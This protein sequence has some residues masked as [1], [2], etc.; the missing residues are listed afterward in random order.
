MGAGALG[1]TLTAG[2]G[3]AHGQSASVIVINE[4]GTVSTN[5]TSGAAKWISDSLSPGAVSSLDIGRIG[6][7]TAWGGN[8]Y[9]YAY[10]YALRGQPAG[11][12]IDADTGVM[13]ISSRLAAGT[14]SFTVVVTNRGNTGLSASFPYTL[15]VATGITSGTPGA[16]QVLH[17]TYDPHSGA[18]GRPT[19]NNWTAVFNAMQAAI[20][21]DQ[22]AAGDGRLRVSIPLHRGVQYDYTNNC[23]LT[24]IQYL[25]VYATGSGA[26]PN[27]RCTVVGGVAT[28]AQW[29]PLFLGGDVKTGSN[30][31]GAFS[32][33]G[34]TMKAHCAPIAAAAAGHTTVT[35]KTSGDA[36][37]IKVG[38]W[39]VVCSG[40]QQ[41][42][43]YPPN[44]TWIDYVRVTAVSGTTVRL[45]RPLK[46]AHSSTFWE[47]LKDD[48]S[49]GVARLVP[50]DTGG[51]GGYVPSM[52]RVGLRVGMTNI[53]FQAN[54][55][56]TTATS[57]ISIGQIDVSYAGCTFVN[58][59]PTI[60]KHTLWTGCT[61]TTS[62]EP[63]K[64]CET[65]VID[66]C[67]ASAFNGTICIGGSTGFLYLLIR[68]SHLPPLQICPRQLR[69]MGGSKIDALGDAHIC[70]PLGW[71]YNGPLMYWSVENSTLQ[72]SSRQPTCFWQQNPSGGWGHGLGFTL[73]T[74]CH[75]G[76]GSAASQLRFPV[77]LAGGSKFENAL[78]WCYAGM[79]VDAGTGFTPTTA[80]YGY[81]SS[82][83]SP[84]DGS[85]LWLNVVWVNGTKPTSGTIHL[86]RNRRL[87][88]VNVTL[89][90]AGGVTTGWLDPGFT[91]TNA[92][93]HAVYGWPA[94]LPPQIKT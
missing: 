25:Q 84:G 32:F 5:A 56:H 9:G 65:L 88:F 69:V 35:L 85:A 82:V 60:T 30:C 71:G 44:L 79:I 29:G 54:P 70:C 58:P 45:D 40:C 62:P 80:N 57:L 41:L 23:W 49:L 21:S 33:Q 28:D 34:G 53:N 77:N 55:N 39:H 15:A 76:T 18:W 52:P 24:G 87:N 59:V 11:L 91:Q 83:T 86:H 51:T 75:W 68:N 7:I 16:N 36:G 43:G 2:A 64:L 92:P 63:D 6:Y 73:G 8:E 31:A 94:G 81:V 3:P 50:L 72:G 67:T 89:G 66:N 74:D 37:K 17:K 61:Y 48:Q 93:G 38:R 4:S 10:T 20:I 27:M 22:K 19:G 46:Y 14:H 1:L 12:S 90:T 42:G 26:L 13:S 47:N 78:D